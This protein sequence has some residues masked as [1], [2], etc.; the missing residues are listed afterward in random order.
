MRRVLL[1]LVLGIALA[2]T[3]AAQQNRIDTITQFAPEL[4]SYGKYDIGVRTISATD[5]N[6]PDILKITA[7]GPMVRYDRTLVLEVWYPAKLPAGQKPGG[8]YHVITREP[9]I[10]ATLYGKA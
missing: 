3:A 4:A 6:R 10:T 8:E 9:A 2:A 1:L 7:G 5:R